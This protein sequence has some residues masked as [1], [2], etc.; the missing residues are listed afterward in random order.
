MDRKKPFGTIRYYR[1]PH[2]LEQNINNA[3]KLYS[4]DKPIGLFVQRLE[5]NLNKLN[6]IYDDILELFSGA[7]IPNFEKLP[8]DSSERGKFA[9]LFKVLNSYLEAAKIQGFK[10]ESIKI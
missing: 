2:T 3:V 6:S 4:G 9:K 7:G 8:D 10:W 1:Y 5:Y